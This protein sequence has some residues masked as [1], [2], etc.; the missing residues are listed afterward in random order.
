MTP[1]HVAR[2][3]LTRWGKWAMARGLGYPSISAHESLRI[4]SVFD[5]GD[6][7]P[8]IYAVDIAVQKALPQHKLILVE[9]YTKTGTIREHAARLRL[10]KSTYF[11]RLELAETRLARELT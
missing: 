2:A 11:D 10:R 7:P 5:L 3:L 1:I 6:L 8:D 4:G 9:H